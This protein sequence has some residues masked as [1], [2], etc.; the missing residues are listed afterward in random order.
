MDDVHATILPGIP[1][2]RLFACFAETAE[3]GIFILDRNEKVVYWSRYLE[4]EYA[5]PARSVLGRV[6]VEVFPVIADEPVYPPIRAALE[7]GRRA[8]IA[9][10]AVSVTINAWT[11]FFRVTV[12]SPYRI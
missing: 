7:R 9:S 4:S 5:V 2:G 10:A 11:G 1:D 6:L 12:I 8:S 3:T